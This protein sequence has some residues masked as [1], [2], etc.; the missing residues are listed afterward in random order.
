MPAHSEAQ[1][2]LFAIAEHHPEKLMPKNRRILGDM[3]KQQIHE[4]ASEKVER[5]KKARN[6]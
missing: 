5:A 1:R 2:R 3:S 6:K 4:F